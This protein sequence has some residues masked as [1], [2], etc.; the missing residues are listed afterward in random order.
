MEI[1]GI[2]NFVFLSNLVLFTWIPCCSTHSN[3]NKPPR[4]IFYWNL[5][6]YKNRFDLLSVVYFHHCKGGDSSS[7][8]FQVQTHKDIV[9]GCFSNVNTLL[10]FNPTTKYS[11][12]LLPANFNPKKSL[13][14]NE[15]L[16]SLVITVAYLL[17][18]APLPPK[19]LMS[20]PSQQYSL[21]IPYRIE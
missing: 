13:P 10:V 12:N 19:T 4:S 21:L 1:K 3:I 2:I 11:A 5:I 14:S 17:T 15:G 16:D 20:L 18:S 6:D 9:L 8:S 7:L